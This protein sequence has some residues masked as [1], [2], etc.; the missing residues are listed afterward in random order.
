MINPINHNTVIPRRFPLWLE[1]GAA[2][3]LFALALHVSISSAKADIYVYERADGSKLISD[4]KQSNAGYRLLKSYTTAP[5]RSRQGNRRYE[6]APIQSQHDALIVNTALQFGLEPAFV[7]AVVH[8]ESAFDAFAVS[9]AGAM[10]LMQLMPDTAAR[11]DLKQDHFNARKNVQVG[12]QH[13]KE[14]MDRYGNDKNLSL[15]AYNAGEGAVQKYAGI[16]PYNETQNYVK[17]VMRLYQ[18]YQPTI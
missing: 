18:L 6:E 10:G 11:Y 5:Y 12:V 1:R 7:K 4:Q 2:I 9:R 3:C 15:A 17:K 16:P 13:L 8:V 14:L